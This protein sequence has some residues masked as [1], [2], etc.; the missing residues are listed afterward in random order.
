MKPVAALTLAF[1]ALSV[2]ALAIDAK[3]EHIVGSVKITNPKGTSEATIG[4]KLSEKDTVVTGEK[5]LAI[6]GLGDGSKFK[7]SQRTELE[8]ASLTDGTDLLLKRGSVFSRVSKQQGPRF[9][10]RTRTATMG[11]RGTEFFAAFGKKDKQF[12][13]TWMCVHKGEVEI[14]DTASL[15][16][17]QV[18]AGFGVLLA[19]GKKISLPK[20]LPWTKGLNW[21]MDLSKGSLSDTA[22]DL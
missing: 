7:V 21:N 17:V 18:K 9:K 3:I 13:D 22:W 8:I 12:N 5:S 4:D 20:V 1:L 6:L 19:E 2:P 14:E 11:V 10:L 16:K 15:E